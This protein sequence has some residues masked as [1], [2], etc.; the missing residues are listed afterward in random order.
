V[1]VVPV[2]EVGGSHV[3]SALVD[4][5]TWTTVEGSRLR[6]PLDP[7]GG[8]DE[9]LQGLAEAARRLGPFAAGGALCVAVPGPFDHNAGVAWLRGNGK[10][11]SLYGVDVRAALA[12]RLGLPGRRIAFVHDGAAFAAGEWLAR[13]PHPRRLV[14]ITLGTG[15]G[16]SFLDH[17]RP[18]TGGDLV[19]EQGRADLLTVRGRQLEDAVS[20]RAMVA[21]Y[22]GARGVAEIAAAAR[23]GD[24]SAVAVVD[25][26]M[27]DLGGSLAP[28]LVRFAA[29][30]VV[31]G[32]SWTRSWDV[33]E[34]PLHRALAAY[35][36]RTPVVVSADVEAAAEAGTAWLG[37][38]ALPNAGSA[39][40]G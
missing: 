14:G 15:V 32:G 22:G 27:T 31:V 11:D 35:E 2:L 36:V 3:T 10:F 19:P 17:G 38:A 21:A 9:L 34:P 33:F 26:A 8:R 29:D 24:G 12:S 23:E 30:V 20:T 39:T 18:V 37:L 25:A 4:P 13:L 6:A 5:A 28:W 1:T 16:S 7:L 40:P